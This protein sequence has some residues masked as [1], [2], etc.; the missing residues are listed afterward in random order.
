MMNPKIKQKWIKALRSRKYKQGRGRLRMGDKYC[1]LGVLMAIQN[2][3]DSL[4]DGR[5]I[6]SKWFLGGLSIKAAY[7]LIAANDGKV[8][9]LTNAEM[10]KH[11]FREIANYL[12]RERRI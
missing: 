1:C 5:P 11:S 4:Y 6:P 3:D 9:I 10:K 7:T 2:A 12:E 8:N